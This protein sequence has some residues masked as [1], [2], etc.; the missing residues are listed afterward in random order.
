MSEPIPDDRWPA[1]DAAIFANDKLSAVKEIRALSGCS[2][3]DA[4]G[5]F[6]VRYAKLRAEAADRFGCSDREYWEGFYS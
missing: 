1:I 6:Y 2:L 5:I 3:G 4:L